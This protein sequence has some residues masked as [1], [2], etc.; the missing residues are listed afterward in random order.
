MSKHDENVTAPP[1]K[2]KNGWSSAEPA[3]RLDRVYRRALLQSCC[4]SN[5][6]FLRL[7]P[8]LLTAQ[9][10]AHMVV[11]DVSKQALILKV[12]WELS[13]TRWFATWLAV[14]NLSCKMPKS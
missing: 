3:I 4:N 7:L 6:K 12:V 2:G 10:G 14:I 11:G 13:C 5:T 1:A 8:A 9:W